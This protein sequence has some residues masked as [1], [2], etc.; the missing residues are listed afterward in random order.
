[1]GERQAQSSRVWRIASA[2]GSNVPPTAKADAIALIPTSVKLARA[3]PGPT[4]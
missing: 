2:I 1:M 3:R 4:R